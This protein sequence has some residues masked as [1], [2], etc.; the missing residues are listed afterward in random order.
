MSQLTAYNV[1]RACVCETNRLSNLDNAQLCNEYD[2]RGLPVLQVPR[3][4]K[5]RDL[6]KYF[7]QDYMIAVVNTMLGRPS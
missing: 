3:A 7:R 5:V 4:G 2:L 1:K 6:V